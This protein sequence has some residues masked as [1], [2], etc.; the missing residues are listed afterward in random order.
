MGKAKRNNRKARVAN[1]REAARNSAAA[2]ARDLRGE[3][4]TGA[5]KRAVLA[6]QEHRYD[7][8]IVLFERAL[9]QKP[10]NVQL[11]LDLGRAYGL[12]YDYDKADE[13][14]GRALKL[15]P[16]SPR[17]MFAIGETYRKIARFD[18]AAEYFRKATLLASGQVNAL[19]QLAEVL[20]RLHALD[21]AVRAVADA[22]RMDP[23]HPNGLFLR[24]KLTRRRGDS[25]QA[26]ALLEEFLAMPPV[27]L[28]EPRWRAWYEL[29]NI[30]DKEG[31]YDEAMRCFLKAKQLL[32]KQ[33]RAMLDGTAFTLQKNTELLSTITSDHFKRWNAERFA[34]E[35]NVALLC[36]HPRSGTTLI[37]QVLDAHP[38][39]V[40][41]DETNIMSDEAYIPLGN[42]FPVTVTPTD[43][44]DQSA[45]VHIQQARDTY[46]SMTEAFL[47]EPLDERV[48]LDKNPELTMILPAIVRMFPEIKV[49]VALRDPRDVCLS[50]FMQPLPMNSVSASYLSIE[51]TFKKYASVMD[52]WLHIRPMLQAPWME[53]RYEDNVVNLEKEAA[54][55]LE[56]LGLPWDPQV[57]NFHERAR[58]K[59]VRSPTYEAVT[60][61]VHNRAVGRWRNYQKFIEPHLNILGPYADAF[62]YDS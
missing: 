37:E 17:A 41:A 49:I 10:N 32:Q 61:P 6:W 30:R 22:L 3:R 11:L 54:T 60:Q 35:Q 59:H 1:E 51:S 9:Q 44:L 43:M 27:R 56:F 36:G 52:T 50:C 53:T 21:E 28:L 47:R 20:E 46:I 31:N 29:G 34:P 26:A 62:G 5:V 14:L 42:H 18:R 23:A 2:M 57:L 39:L 48:L 24:A 33:G 55:A 19:L 25:P 13:Y 15:S 12:R 58:Q 40:S 8:A 7:E 38:G 45:P 16:D 4:P